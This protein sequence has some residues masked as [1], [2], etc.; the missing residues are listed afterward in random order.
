MDIPTLPPEYKAQM[1]RFM[2]ANGVGP[3]LNDWLNY[4]KSRKIQVFPVPYSQ[5]LNEVGKK[6]GITQISK[7]TRMINVLTIGISLALFKYGRSLT[8]EAVR[9]TFSGKQK[10]AEMNITALDRLRLC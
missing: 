3:T 9:A 2:E 5:L 6:L 8:A 7:I 1:Q 10:I 4:A